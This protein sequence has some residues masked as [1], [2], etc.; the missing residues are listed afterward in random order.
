MNLRRLIAGWIFVLLFLLVGTA[1][2]AIGSCSGNFLDGLQSPYVGNAAQKGEVRFGYNAKLLNNP[3]AVLAAKLV[4]R[5]SGSTQLTCDSANC[6]ASGVSAPSQYAGDFPLFAG[7]SAVFDVPY[8]GVQSLSGNGSNQYQRI[9]LNSEAQLTINSGTQTFYIDQLILEYRS[10]L[11]LAPGDYWIGSLTSNYQSQIQVQGSGQVRLFIRDDLSLG[12]SSLLNSPAVNSGGDPNKLYLYAYRSLFLNNQATLSG[13]AYSAFSQGTNEGIILGSASYVFGALSSENIYLGT[14]SRVSYVAPTGCAVGTGI[15]HFEFSYAANALTCNPQ[16]VAIRACADTSC[17]NLYTD[18]VSV[19]LS[20]ASGWT[21]TAPATVSGGNVITFSGGI[22]SVQLRSSAVDDVAIGVVSSTPARSGSNVCSTNGCTIAYAKSGFI[23]DVP[24]LIAAKSREGITLRA[25]REGDDSQACVPAFFKVTRT[26]SFSSDYDDPASGNMPVWVNDVPVSSVPADI[27]LTFDSNGS[28]SLKVR[29]D[30]AGQMF[31]NA[32]YAGTVTNGDVGLSMAGSDLFVSRPAGF[33]VESPSPNSGCSSGD[34]SCSAFVPAGEDF[35]L[36]VKAVAWQTDSDTDLCA[37]NA[38]TPNYRQSEV[39]LDIDKVA[40]LTTYPVSLGVTSVNFDA[41][42]MGES[43]LP[44]QTVSEVG[45]F[46]IAATSPSYF[47]ETITGASANIGRFYPASFVL[48]KPLL[49]PACSVGFTYAGLVGK[50]GPPAQLAKDGE[51]FT[52]TGT[53]SARNKGGGVTHNYID[54]FVKLEEAD[55]AYA[56]SDGVGTLAVASTTLTVPGAAGDGY[57]DYSGN[58]ATFLFDA[59]Q[60]PHTLKVRVT[61]TDDDSV[62]GSATDE[63][64]SDFRLGRAR[65]GNAHGSELS[66]LLLPFTVE[67]FNGEAYVPN[68][69]DSCTHFDPA[70]LGAFQANGSG[71]GEPVLSYLNS[72]GQVAGPYVASGGT[73]L[74]GGYLLSAPG[75]GSTGSTVV[76]YD[77]PNWLRFDWNNDGALDDASSR[78]TFG[79]YRGSVPLIFRREIYRQ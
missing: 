61:A 33:C 72:L 73:S 16:P 15:D 24:M 53:L 46:T 7:F 11:R 65:I 3:D 48:E 21:A 26:L 69:L 37:G 78:A 57:L 54:D 38:T 13:Y 75:A 1:Q 64:G 43:G 56:D 40:P 45:V 70:A 50:V 19:A 52:I 63:D 2:A 44:D 62:T 8:Q 77:T 29:Y 27:S 20:P 6:T 35:L 18:S 17:N 74:L 25:V 5:N 34:A 36:R 31:L 60:A 68:Q 30:D 79:L 14:D 12:S 4:S 47:G 22:A 39:A 67:Y 59:P 71:S 55:I 42:D 76:T 41:A 51:L 23:F 58:E 66:D 32:T 28:T 49:T 10:I 9:K